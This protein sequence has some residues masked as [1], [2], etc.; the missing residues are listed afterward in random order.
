[1]ADLAEDLATALP[2]PSFVRSS[3]GRVPWT[4]RSPRP[5]TATSWWSPRGRRAMPARSSRPSGPG[6]QVPSVTLARAAASK[7]GELVDVELID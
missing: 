3:T 6:H 4:S 2:T 7:S 1:M 5:E